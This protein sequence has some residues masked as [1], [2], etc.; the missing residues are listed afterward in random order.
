M[1]ERGAG[2]LQIYF[3]SP[4][5]NHPMIS[6]T[7]SRSSDK[8]V[9]LASNSPH[10][11]VRILVI[12][13][14]NSFNT[15]TVTYTRGTDLSGTLQGAGGI[16]GLLARSSGYSSGSWSTHN[17]YHAEG[18]GN[19]T[20]LVNSSQTVAAT[21]RFSSKEIHATRDHRKD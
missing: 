6:T 16:G 11:G 2:T 10:T 20:Y 17:H 4:I 9:F 18:N 12:Q 1:R 7:K 3:A 21:Y 13:E 14:R 5:S 8:N 15:P 19:I